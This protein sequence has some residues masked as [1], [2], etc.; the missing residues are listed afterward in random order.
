MT[1]G[2]A[3]HAVRRIACLASLVLNIVIFRTG[4]LA[5]VVW[6]ISSFTAIS[7]DTP[8]CRVLQVFG[9]ALVLWTIAQIPGAIDLMWL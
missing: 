6:L 9:R 7:I 1:F 4:I 2:T 5:V 8:S 3:L